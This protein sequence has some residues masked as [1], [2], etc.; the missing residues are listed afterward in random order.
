[1]LGLRHNE[2][3]RVFDRLVSK[4]SVIRLVKFFGCS[5]SIV[6]SLVRQYKQTEKSIDTPRSSNVRQHQ[7]DKI[8]N[9][10]SLIYTSSSRVQLQLPDDSTFQARWLE[11]RVETNNFMC[12]FL[13]WA[14]SNLRRF[15]S[16]TGHWI[17]VSVTQIYR[18]LISD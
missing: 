11:T 15:E 3:N 5:C 14:L 1:M 17:C 8:F 9:L 6:Y 16:N 13:F 4:T 7:W 12:Y 18:E 10:L 2:H